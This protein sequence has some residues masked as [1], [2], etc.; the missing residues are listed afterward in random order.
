MQ[1]Q[2]IRLGGIRVSRSSSL[3]WW[4]E[5]WFENLCNALRNQSDANLHPRKRACKICDW[6]LLSTKRIKHEQHVCAPH[7]LRNQQRPRSIQGEQ[8]QIVQTRWWLR[9][10][11]LGWRKWTQ[12]VVKSYFENHNAAG[13]KSWQ[14]HERNQRHH[15]Q[16]YDH[17]PTVYVAYLQVMSARGS[18]K[19][20]VLPNSRFWYHDWQE[21]QTMAHWSKLITLFQNRF[22]FGLRCQKISAQGL[23]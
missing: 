8:R 3:G 7:K 17:R 11:R 22:S 12:K 14:G 6:T 4:F 19:F 16:N 2:R 18:W 21:V 10:R 15:R 9:W 23:F 1:W 13:R 5:V 20:N